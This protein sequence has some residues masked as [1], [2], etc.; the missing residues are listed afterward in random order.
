MNCEYR[1]YKDHIF[2]I[3]L[4]YVYSNKYF[5]VARLSPSQNEYPGLVYTGLVTRISY[6]YLKN[7]NNHCAFYVSPQFM[8]KDLHYNNKKFEDDSGVNLEDDY[9]E[10]GAKG[11]NDYAR[12][13][14]AQIYGLDFVAG[15]MYFIGNTNSK[16]KLYLNFCFGFGFNYRHRNINTLWS[17][18]IGEPTNVVAVGHSTMDQN[19]FIP[20]LGI[21]MGLDLDLSKH[22]AIDDNK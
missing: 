3:T 4:G 10:T 21:K 6:S 12:N 20:I 16:L 17:N 15:W 8:F 1:P 11:E 2:G 19:F 14:K 18:K 5:Q 9:K 7:H 13:E 22:K